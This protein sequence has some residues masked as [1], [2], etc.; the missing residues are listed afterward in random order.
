MRMQVSKIFAVPTEQ[1]SG[2]PVEFELSGILSEWLFATNFWREF[3][4]GHGTMFDQF[5]EDEVDAAIV[6]SVSAALEM[7]IEALRLSDTQSVEFVYRRLQDGQSLT[8]NTSKSDLLS[9]LVALDAFL[10]TAAQQN[11]TMAFAL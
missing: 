10:K 8:A 3:N 2:R 5:E 4:A 11:P 1:H 9:E 7:Q 6:K